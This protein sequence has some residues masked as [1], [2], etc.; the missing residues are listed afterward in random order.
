MNHQHATNQNKEVCLVVCQIIKKI[1]FLR[2]YTLGI[3]FKQ[4]KAL[5]WPTTP[6]AELR[7]LLA[8][9]PCSMFSVISVRWGALWLDRIGQQVDLWDTLAD[10]SLP[11]C[12][13]YLLV[14]LSSLSSVQLVKMLVMKVGP[15]GKII[16]C[17]PI[18]LTQS[19]YIFG[20]CFNGLSVGSRK[21]WKLM[22]TAPRTRG[23]QKSST[24]MMNI[25]V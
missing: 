18:S 24:E 22:W 23:L 5:K 16:H 10:L 12:L 9:N 13:F 15:W 19:L 3:K 21:S 17:R 6:L 8:S 7:H 4:N 14:F 20:K 2:V 25:G 11:L 1:A